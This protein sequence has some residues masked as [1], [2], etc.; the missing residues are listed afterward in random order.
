VTV[1]IGLQVHVPCRSPLGRRCWEVGLLYAPTI[2]SSSGELSHNNVNQPGPIKRNDHA[3]SIQ[4]CSYLNPHKCTSCHPLVSTVAS[5][6]VSPYVVVTLFCIVQI[7]KL[8]KDRFPCLATSNLSVDNE[9]VHIGDMGNRLHPNHSRS[10]MISIWPLFG[11]H[12][13]RVAIRN[14]Y[15]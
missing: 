12:P 10:V 14:V 7:Q 1:A 6:P 9:L 11:T 4:N 5:T 8:M 2:M 15:S 3:R 13:L